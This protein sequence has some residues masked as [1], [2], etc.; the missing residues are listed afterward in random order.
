MVV[1]TIYKYGSVGK[2]E[3]Q[4]LTG[5]TKEQCGPHTF[6]FTPGLKTLTEA[7]ASAT[8]EQ[9]NLTRADGSLVQLNA[10]VRR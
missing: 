1:F 7:L 5:W 6:G 9:G 10:G 3:N 4:L 8:R 2:I